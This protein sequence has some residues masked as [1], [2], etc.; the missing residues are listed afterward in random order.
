M[1]RG[2]KF[3][4]AALALAF[5]F[6]GS[7]VANAHF[8]NGGGGNDRLVGHEHSDHLKG[9][10]GCDTLLMRGADDFGGGDAHDLVGE[11]GDVDLVG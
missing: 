11:V 2:P 6:A 4:V 1:N 5:L 10:S 8:E 7:I 3:G 9:N